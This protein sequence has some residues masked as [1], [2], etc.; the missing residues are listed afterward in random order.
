MSEHEHESL[1]ID[2]E[3]L[4]AEFYT[5]PE[6][7][8]VK[9]EIGDSNVRMLYSLVSSLTDLSDRIVASD[10][11]QTEI[12]NGMLKLQE[13]LAADREA[14]TAA[15]TAN[16]E[17]VI[18]VEIPETVVNVTV[19]EPQVTVNVPEAQV[20][21]N[22]PEPVV[23]VTVPTAQKKINVVRDPVSGMIAS[24]TVEEVG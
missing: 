10:Q 7:P 14:L 24:A 8:A 5:E 9:V 19:P 4:L 20:T 15:L 3:A 18:N 21:V 13:Q 11:R 22:V 2:R 16:P 17:P 6:P 23:N 12:I 1:E